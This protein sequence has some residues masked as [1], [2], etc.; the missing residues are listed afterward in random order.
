LPELIYLLTGRREMP[1]NVLDS[2]A[3]GSTLLSIVIEL[4]C[5]PSL[6]G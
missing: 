2:A 4:I 5:H 6:S 1:L 3:V